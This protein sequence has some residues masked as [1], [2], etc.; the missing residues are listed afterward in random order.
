MFYGAVFVLL[1]C[2]WV[3]VC[4]ASPRNDTPPIPS[5]LFNSLEE[6]SRLV[7][8]AYCVGTTGVQPPFQCLSHCVEFPDLQLL[9][10]SVVAS[11]YTHTINK[12]NPYL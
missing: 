1:H 12:I 7:D 8:I 3:A 4:T 5:E 11:E 6:L 10:V 9:T 2:I